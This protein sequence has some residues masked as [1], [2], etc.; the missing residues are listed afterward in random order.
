MGLK[1]GGSGVI[2]MV[3]Y[4]LIF[5]V[6]TVRGGSGVT[7]M[8]TSGFTSLAVLILLLDGTILRMSSTLFDPYRSKY[9][10]VI[11]TARET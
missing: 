2:V 7:V 6:P 11:A 3:V 10:C 8:V 1:R 5:T 4:L 9:C